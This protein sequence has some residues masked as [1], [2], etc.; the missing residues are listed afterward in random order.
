MDFCPIRGGDGTGGW[1]DAV[2]HDA[3]VRVPTPV[4]IVTAL[5][6]GVVGRVRETQE[7]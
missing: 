6:V 4:W 2:G 3:G 7:T 1:G 5:V